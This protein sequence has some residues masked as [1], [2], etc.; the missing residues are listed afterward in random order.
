MN[1]ENI[2]IE[3][4]KNGFNRNLLLDNYHKIHSDDKELKKLIELFHVEKKKNYLDL[5]TGNGYVAFELAKF[6]KEVNVNGLD[7]AEK[8]IQRNKEISLE[9]GINNIKFDVYDGLNIPYEDSSFDG[10]ISRLAIHHFPDIKNTIK[11]I[12]RIL[13]KMEKSS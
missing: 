13:K 1:E 5:G 6:N 9:N 7:I 4:A 8:A 12:D 11:Q 10:V 3:K 2:I